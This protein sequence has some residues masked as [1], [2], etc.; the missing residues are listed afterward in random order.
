MD[1]GLKSAHRSTA[2]L[3]KTCEDILMRCPRTPREQN[4]GAHLSSRD[5][6]YAAFFPPSFSFPLPFF[7]LLKRARDWCVILFSCHCRRIVP[8]FNRTRSR[9]RSATEAR[10]ITGTAPLATAVPAVVVTPAV[11]L[12]RISRIP[13]QGTVRLMYMQCTPVYH[14]F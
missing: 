2:H 10:V 3:P 8:A 4:C 5:C 6:W 7:W 1:D 12:A 11:P 9:T 14:R 13:S